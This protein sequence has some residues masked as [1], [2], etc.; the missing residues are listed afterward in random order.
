ML[1]GFGCSCCLLFCVLIGL[2]WVCG[3]LRLAFVVVSC[4]LVLCVVVLLFCF[5]MFCMDLFGLC[6]VFV[7]CGLVLFILFC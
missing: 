4:C 3:S 6:L 2:A 5:V 1:L 7:L